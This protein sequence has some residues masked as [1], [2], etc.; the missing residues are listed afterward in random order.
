MQRPSFCH[1]SFVLHTYIQFAHKKK[2]ADKVLILTFEKLENYIT[3]VAAL[4]KKEYKTKNCIFDA[5]LFDLTVSYYTFIIFNQC[6]LIK[7]IFVISFGT[8]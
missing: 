2:F 8:E 5:V 6:L 4:C 7:L 1:C 3:R